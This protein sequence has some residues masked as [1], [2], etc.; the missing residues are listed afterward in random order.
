[1]RLKGHDVVVGDLIV[2]FYSTTDELE[3]EDEDTRWLMLKNI[4]KM[5][6]SGEMFVMFVILT[7]DGER[8]H[9]CLNRGNSYEVIRR[10]SRTAD[11]G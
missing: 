8:V 6:H 11:H 5:S 9:V 10:V 7:E 1:V 2:G 4:T 3:D